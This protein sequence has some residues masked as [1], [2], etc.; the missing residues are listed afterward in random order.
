MPARP[1]RGP[2]CALRSVPV[3]WDVA[4]RASSVKGMARPQGS[5]RVSVFQK[6][7]PWYFDFSKL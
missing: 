4:L 6:F 5:L 1:Q 7:Y 3:H 2:A